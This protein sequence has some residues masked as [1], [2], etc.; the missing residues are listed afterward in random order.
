MVVLSATSTWA[1]PALGWTA[2]A[3]LLTTILYQSFQQ[4]KARENGGASPWLFFGQAAANVLFLTYASLQGDPV[5]IVTNGL[6]L[7][8]TLFGVWVCARQ[9]GGPVE[10]VKEAVEELPGVG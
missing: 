6:L 8:A 9:H 7:L 1:T 4:L 2:S 10:L 5:F 3:V